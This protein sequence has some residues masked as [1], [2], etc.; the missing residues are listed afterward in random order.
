LA[1]L[2]SNTTFEPVPHARDIQTTVSSRDNRKGAAITD[3][4]GYTGA[5]LIEQ[6]AART[7]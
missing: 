6:G 7:R 4:N 1:T 3:A 2:R 5:H